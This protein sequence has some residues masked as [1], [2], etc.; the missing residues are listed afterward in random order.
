M[1]VNYSHIKF[2]MYFKTH[3]KITLYELFLKKK[4][5]LQQKKI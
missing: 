3:H 5:K 4:Y 2:Y 1:Y